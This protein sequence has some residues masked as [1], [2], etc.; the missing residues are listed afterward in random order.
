MPCVNSGCGSLPVQTLN[1]CGDKL[2]GGGDAAFIFDCS[3]TIDFSDTQNLASNIATEVNAGR[4]ALFRKIRIGVPAPSPVQAGATYVAGE[5]VDTVTYDRAGTWMDANVNATNDAAYT[6]LNATAGGVYRA[7]LFHL[8][9]EG[10]TWRLFDADKGIK[11]VGGSVD[12]DDTG[13]YVH[14]EF[15]F[16][17]KNKSGVLT[18]IAG[19]N[20]PV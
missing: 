11:F 7:I 13:D 4:A 17:G 6:T 5:T 3:S 9:D 1:P 18:T 19:A 8:A 14:Y 20:I 12:P 16:N 10:D 2:S 15:T